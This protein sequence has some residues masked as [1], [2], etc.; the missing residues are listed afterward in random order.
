MS[1][2]VI[3]LSRNCQATVIPMGDRVVLE[4]GCAVIIRQ[5]LGNSVTVE[6]PNGLFRIDRDNL[7]ALGEEHLPEIKAQI[8][9]TTED[10]ADSNEPFEEKHV[11][12]VLKQCF[13]PEIPINIVDLG[14][15][16]D[17][18]IQKNQK[19]LYQ[20]DVKMTLTAQGCGMGPVIAADAKEKIEDLSAVE[21]AN[22]QIVWDPLWNPNMISE[23]GKKK[24]GLN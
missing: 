17:L 20:V 18:Q 6:S 14:L 8:N 7:D 9:K 13:D 23:E 10:C 3:Y 19:D 12:D 21:F 16:Y 4:Q 24:L 22:V 11:W 15:I 2:N 1:D 5:A